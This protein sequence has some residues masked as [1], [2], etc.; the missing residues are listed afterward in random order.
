MVKGVIDSNNRPLIE[1][2][3]GWQHGVQ[4]IIAL[5][6]T[7]FSGE[8]KLSPKEALNLNLMTTHTERVQLANN[9][10]VDMQASLAMVSLEKT[11]K[12]VNVLIS[13]GLPIVGVGLLKRFEYILKINFKNNYLEL[14]K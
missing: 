12:L 8:L 9:K 7:G 2:T 14:R 13:E 6:D 10:S 4:S 1:I 5:V 11:A 3:I